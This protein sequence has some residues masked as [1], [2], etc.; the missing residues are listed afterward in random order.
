MTKSRLFAFRAALH[1]YRP[2]PLPTK[3]TTSRA[4]ADD[5][6]EPGKTAVEAL[7]NRHVVKPITEFLMKFDDSPHRVTVNRLA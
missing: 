3:R 4:R 6:D 7:A 2:Q 5:P 1:F